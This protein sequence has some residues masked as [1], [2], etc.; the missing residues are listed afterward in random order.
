MPLRERLAKHNISTIFE[1]GWSSL[2]NGDLLNRAESDGF[3]ALITTDQN[4]RYQQALSGRRLAIV[5]LLTTSWPRIALLSTEIAERI[6]SLRHGDYIE[7][8]VP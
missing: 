7:I 6:D 1:L 2:K 4:I 3:D 8:A 5:V